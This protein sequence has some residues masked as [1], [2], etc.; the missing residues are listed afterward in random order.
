MDSTELWR[1][2]LH[3]LNNLLAGFQGVLELSD[4]RLPLDP[5]NRARLEASLEDGK[6]LIAMGR[7]LALGRYPDPGMAPWNEWQAGLEERLTPMAT[8]FRCRIQVVDAG[9]S[10]TSWPAP[11]EQDWAAAFT[12]QILPWAAPGN[13]CLEA[14]AEPDHWSL[15]WLT[16]APIPAALQADP[17]E[18]LARNLPA[19]WLKDVAERE[20]ITVEKT[21]R[22][23]VARMGRPRAS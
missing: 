11:I 17:P 2:T 8:L 21:P 7:A 4:P 14:S 6:T 22:G 12:R 18:G 15:L 1:A 10:G 5:L 13:L 20:A 9:A 3:D 23:L 19:L 16:D